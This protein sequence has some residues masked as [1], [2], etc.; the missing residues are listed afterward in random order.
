MGRVRRHPGNRER[1]V[2]QRLPAHAGGFPDRAN[3]L[4]VTFLPRPGPV[5]WALGTGLLLAPPAAQSAGAARIHRRGGAAAAPRPVIGAAAARLN[6]LQDISLK[7]L[8]FELFLLPAPR[9]ITATPEAVAAAPLATKDQ[10]ETSRR[11]VIA[12]RPVPAVDEAFREGI[13][14]KEREFIDRYRRGRVVADQAWVEPQSS[15]PDQIGRLKEIGNREEGLLLLVALR[16]SRSGEAP[17]IWIVDT[18]AYTKERG[19]LR[20]IYHRERGLPARPQ[21]EPALR[22][23]TSRWDA[24]TWE[25]FAAELRNL[26]PLAGG[27][28]AVLRLTL[29]AGGGARSDFTSARLPKAG[30][31][32]ER[33]ALP[34]EELSRSL[35]QGTA[36]G[37]ADN[38][39]RDFMRRL[40]GELA[41]VSG[42]A[43]EIAGP[44]LVEPGERTQWSSGFFESFDGT[45]LHYR[46]RPGEGP[47]VLLIHG[48]GLHEA[49]LERLRSELLP[50][51]ALMVL[52]REG[53][54]ASSPRRVP[55]SPRRHLENQ[56]RDV[57]AAA[58]EAARLSGGPVDVLGH[59]LG[60]K[61]VLALA[62]SARTPLALIR[63][64]YLV[65]PPPDGWQ[66]KLSAS[67]QQRVNWLRLHYRMA[68]T[69][70][71]PARNAYIHN[72]AL[73]AVRY[74]LDRL[75]RFAPAELKEKAARDFLAFLGNPEREELL[76]L[77]TLS[78]YED[79]P[80]QGLWGNALVVGFSDDA[81]V[82]FAEVEALARGLEASARER[83]LRFRFAALPGGHFEPLVDPGSLTRALA[84]F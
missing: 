72:L 69:R 48:L 29:L 23:E 18:E 35:E 34:M 14:R 76:I 57:S 3:G 55:E 6:P 44:A 43:P 50:G 20:L 46:I 10:P 80:D 41:P 81:T 13:F 22:E 19:I 12:G 2:A 28:P 32:M 26:S 45:R 62:R 71:G 38:A 64:F 53:Y 59:S 47:M 54:G 21:A 39:E 75:E 4:P 66:S 61:H 74:Y 30:P 52:D 67:E 70:D 16:P 49:S 27:G 33:L 56:A 17:G 84:G 9:A 51:R 42:H 8:S 73:S 5:L 1:C 77:E 7:T 82:P 79:L 63:N 58:R 15:V 83:G 65:S 25:E 60:A 24:M 40:G 36:S 78:A 31:L 11:E 37:M 68:G